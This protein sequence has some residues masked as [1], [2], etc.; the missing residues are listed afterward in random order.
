MYVLTN[1][2]IRTFKETKFNGV[3]YYSDMFPWGGRDH[4]G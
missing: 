2:K 1:V 3:R 4:K